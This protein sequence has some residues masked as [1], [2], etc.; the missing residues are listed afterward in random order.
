[1]RQCG[2]MRTHAPRTRGA[3]TTRTGHLWRKLVCNRRCRRCRTPPVNTGPT[4]LRIAEAENRHDGWRLRP[5]PHA[6]HTLP[7][8]AD[9]THAQLS[10]VANQE[11]YH[12]LQVRV[13][14]GSEHGSVP[15][16]TA[17]VLLA[18]AREA[19]SNVVRHAGAKHV[20]VAFETS[21]VNFTLVIA[22]D[23][24]GFDPAVARPGHFGIRSMRERARALGAH[25]QVTSAAGAG[26]RL[27]LCVPRL[28]KQGDQLV[29]DASSG[30][31][32]R[33][34]EPASAHSVPTTLTC[35]RSTGRIRT[36][37]SRRRRARWNRSSTRPRFATSVSLTSTL[38]RWPDS[39][40]RTKSMGCNHRTTCSDPK[41]RTPSFRTASHTISES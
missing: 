29:R 9:G 41:P 26:T 6:N 18:I 33:G 12:G 23:G 19:L 22:D 21:A 38:I 2:S 16:D 40:E 30:W 3:R 32:R 37:P 11:R 14:L 31:L 36:P 24:R 34:L 35:I 15:P 17:R 13:A 39:N 10:A 20:D 7:K 28:R 27:Q 5:R 8:G 25:V 1:M 4:S